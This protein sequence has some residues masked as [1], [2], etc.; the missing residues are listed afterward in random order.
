MCTRAM[1]SKG[2]GDREIEEWGVKGN[3]QWQL[4]LT[5]GGHDPSQLLPTP[6]QAQAQAQA[7]I[8]TGPGQDTRQSTSALL[9]WWMVGGGCSSPASTPGSQIRIWIARRCLF[10][11]NLSDSW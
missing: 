6:A 1:A 10:V 7:G 11:P 3:G 5:E 9:V 2:R 4:G 8:R